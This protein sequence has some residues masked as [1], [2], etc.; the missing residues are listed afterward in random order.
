MHFTKS[1]VFIL[2]MVS[3]ASLLANLPESVLGNFVDRK[4]LLGT[5]GAVVVI[6]MFRYLQVLLLL[7]VTILAIGANLPQ[8]MA[9]TLGVSHAM[10]IVALGA[11]VAVALLG[12]VFK[13]LPMPS[14]A[15]G[16]D[17]DIVADP[18]AARQL[19]LNAISKGDLVTLRGLLAMNAAINFILNGT[20]PLHLATEKGYSNVV[21]L[22]LDHG[23]D[24]LAV[25][26]QGQTPLDV[27]LAKKKY[28]RTTEI[29]YAVTMP[30]IDELSEIQNHRSGAGVPA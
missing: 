23:A 5:L 17:E 8:E 12:R 4:M 20:T 29:L 7:V 18:S 19:L 14:E 13:L 28:V 3:L 24:F 1:Q 22:L 6:A 21:Q 9:Q 2:G 10:L 27:A 16:P 15:L 30:H 11:L 26:A 25:N